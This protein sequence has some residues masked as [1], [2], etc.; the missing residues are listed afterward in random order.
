MPTIKRLPVAWACAGNQRRVSMV[1]CGESTPSVLPDMPKA[2]HA[3]LDCAAAHMW[4]QKATPTGRRKAPGVVI[5]ATIAL[6][7][8]HNHNNVCWLQRA[9]VDE[10][11]HTTQVPWAAAHSLKY[12]YL[13]CS[14]LL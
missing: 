7:F 8:P 9:V 12:D 6:D 3:H 2:T 10:A 1:K 4:R 13:L 14:A 11:L 5:E